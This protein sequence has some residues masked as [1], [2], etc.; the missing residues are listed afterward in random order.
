MGKGYGT[1]IVEEGRANAPILDDQWLGT[2]LEIGAIG[3]IAWLWLMVRAVRRLG[4][5]ARDDLSDS[6]LLAAGLAA[7]V[8]AFGIGML[9]YDAFA[10]IQVTFLFFILLSFAAA[11]LAMR[12]DPA[13]AAAPEPRSPL[14]GLDPGG[15][16]A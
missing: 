10:F 12:D 15:S 16:H 14:A 7:S 9:T 1:L 4:R 11:A 5:R 3:A 2:L 8:T 13:A 6:G